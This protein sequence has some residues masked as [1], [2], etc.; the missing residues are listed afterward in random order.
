MN[1]DH[2][3]AFSQKG[4]TLLFWFFLVFEVAERQFLQVLTPLNSLD[5]SRSERA[6]RLKHFT[7]VDI[8]ES[9]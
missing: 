4:V 5:T 2:A 9:N 3:L 6:T 7:K 8:S 1:S